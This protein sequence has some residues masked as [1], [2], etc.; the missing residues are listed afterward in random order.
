VQQNQ[1]DSFVTITEQT[2]DQ[3]S[4]QYELVLANILAGENVRLASQLVQRLAPQGRLVLSGILI[5]QEQQV[6]DGF[7]PFNLKKLSI[8][9]RDEW[10]CIV[11]Q[12]L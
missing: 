4:G 8:S 2:L 1:L 12:R 6:I 10:T 9:H 7:S 5:E 3:I 11:Y